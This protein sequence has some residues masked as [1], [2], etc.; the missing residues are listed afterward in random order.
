MTSRRELPSGEGGTTSHRISKTGSLEI[1]VNVVAA[2][3]GFAAFDP[4]PLALSGS[5]PI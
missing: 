2:K 3:V 5:A 1:A 4:G